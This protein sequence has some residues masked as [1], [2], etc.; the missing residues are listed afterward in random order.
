MIVAGPRVYVIARPAIDLDEIA[1]FL[2][3]RDL[4][5]ARSPGAAPAEELVEVCGRLCYLSFSDDTAR[6]RYPVERYL[7]HLVDS[8]HESVLEHAAW[9]LVLDGVS[10]AFTH[11]LVRHRAGFAYSQLSQQYADHAAF[12]LVVPAEIA[13]DEGLLSLWR[14]SLEGLAET[15]ATLAAGVAAETRDTERRERLRRIRSAARS[16][17]PNATATAIAV[18]ANARALRHFLSMRG[19]ILGDVEMRR[20]AAAIHERIAPDAPAL[21]SDFECVAGPDGWPLVRRREP[22]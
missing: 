14:D 4:R 12:D 20:V 5:W 7:R 22:A 2:A 8:G 18:S 17:L 16:L 19:A 10:R 13:A 21:F 3:D 9:T 6:V 11:Q 1:R 15:Y